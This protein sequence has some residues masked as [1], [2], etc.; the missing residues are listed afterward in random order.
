MRAA[1]AGLAL[2]WPSATLSA[3]AAV[4]PTEVSVE[5]A[6]KPYSAWIDKLADF[7]RG[8][9][10]DEQDVERLLDQPEA[11][12]SLETLGREGE[13]GET[14]QG[15]DA[16]AKAALADPDYRAWAAEAGLDPR[17]W[18]RKVMRVSTVVLL[19][20]SEE[21]RED[22]REQQADFAATIEA[23]CATVGEEAC[24]Q[25]RGAL[26]ESR[27]MSEAVA[28][29]LARLVPP[30]ARER[31]VFERHAAELLEL[32]GD[33]AEDDPFGEVEEYEEGDVEPDSDGP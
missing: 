14:P 23:R 24:R 26:E 19:I 31:E 30:S 18:L 8:I 11:L 21:L 2:L 28:A 15:F 16:A 1:L 6:V 20:A 32:F 5:Q 27:A 12:R 9:E 17:L 29:A 22:E 4:A 7:T 13:G 33:P 3:A 10:F 25:M